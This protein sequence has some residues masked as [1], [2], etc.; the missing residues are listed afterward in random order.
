MPIGTITRHDTP[1]ILTAGRCASGEGYGWDLLRVIPP[2]I[3]TGQAAGEIA[4]LAVETG[5]NVA[6]VNIT[7]LQRRLTQD[8]IMVHFPDEY[9]PEDKTLIIHGKNASGAEGHI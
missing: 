7:E 1:N 5:A 2:A 6:D 9:V 4:S 3:L 8:N